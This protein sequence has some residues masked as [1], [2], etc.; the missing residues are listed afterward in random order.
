M[1][2]TNKN[3]S[4]S[5]K[6]SMCDYK[7][8]EQAASKVQRWYSDWKYTTSL[9]KKLATVE[10]S[11]NVVKNCLTEFHSNDS[12]EQAH[13]ML[14]NDSYTRSL[15]KVLQIIATSKMLRQIKHKTSILH[16]TR[17]ISS[18]FMISKF[19]D[20][21]LFSDANDSETSTSQHFEVAAE[22]KSCLVD[23]KSLFTQFEK[24]MSSTDSS[25]KCRRFRFVFSTFVFALSAFLKSFEDWRKA[26]SQRL[27]SS[28][29]ESFAQ[30]YSVYI[31]SMRKDSSD[32]IASP[33]LV[34]ASQ[35]QLERIRNA[36]A[37]TIG[38]H[39]AASRIEEICAAVEAAYHTMATDMPNNADG[40]TSPVPSTSER[41]PFQ[42]PISTANGAASLSA[43]LLPGQ[44]LTRPAAA[45][46]TSPGGDVSFLTELTQ[47]TLSPSHTK[48]L[49]K[50]S[51]LA[52]IDQE[53]LA[54]EIVLNPYYRLPT[55]AADSAATSAT[56]AQQQQQGYAAISNSLRRSDSNQGG[57]F[58]ASGGSNK[59][60]LCLFIL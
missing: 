33:E 39:E 32:E 5:A 54:Y 18:A 26:D 10:V 56:V 47:S 35:Q 31:A 17:V 21:V 48:V 19:P 34:V 45:L 42:S 25:T 38:K 28:L 20:Q 44:M 50:L 37:R 4:F 59:G 13:I 3:P 46:G 22:A 58:S 15:G 7:V 29:Q 51:L 27:A 8:D 43:T 30:T 14:Q 24:L 1:Q 6:M 40:E 9:R 23:A 57:S 36:L 53:R 12:F 60:L 16:L 55:P 52:G 2:H 11:A 41:S 49:D